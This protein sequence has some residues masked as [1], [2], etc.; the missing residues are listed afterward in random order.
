M[1]ELISFF[2]NPLEL[3]KSSLKNLTAFKDPHAQRG[4]AYLLS[5]LIKALGILT[6]EKL[7]VFKFLEESSAETKKE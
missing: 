4:S 7:E 3:A 5:G 1:P 2:D 6:V